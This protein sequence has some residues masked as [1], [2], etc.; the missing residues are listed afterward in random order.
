[1]IF[2]QGVV[3]VPHT[4]HSYTDVKLNSMKSKAWPFTTYQMLFSCWSFDWSAA[5]HMMDTGSVIIWIISL[6]RL[7]SCL[8][9][10]SDDEHPVRALAHTHT[11][12]HTRGQQETL[13][14][15]ASHV[16]VCHL[17]R[18]PA[19][20]CS[21]M[22]VIIQYNSSPPYDGV[23]FWRTRRKPTRIQV[24]NT[25]KYPRAIRNHI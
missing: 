23:P 5:W 25:H 19:T 3:S 17:S 10:I 21:Y 14:T 12:T 11:H 4:W 15:D 1:M 2:C 18:K 22:D 13:W 20:K 24:G 16:S 8:V 7:M 9:I 6:L